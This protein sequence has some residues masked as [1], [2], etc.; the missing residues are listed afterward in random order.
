MKNPKALFHTRLHFLTYLSAILFAFKFALCGKNSFNKF[1]FRRVLKF[2]IQTFTSRI[3]SEHFSFEFKME[4]CVSCIAFK[5][6][7]DDDILLMRAGVEKSQQ[8][9]HAWTVHEIAATG[10]IIRK[11]GRYQI[12]LIFG[13]F[14]ATVFLTIKATSFIALFLA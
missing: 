9:N 4:F 10:N 14:T 5:V 7:K 13:I 12:A 6:V 1:T 8:G 11:H 3:A 2:E